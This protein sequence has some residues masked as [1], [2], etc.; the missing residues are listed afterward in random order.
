MLISCSRSTVLDLQQV[1]VTVDYAICSIEPLAVEDHFTTHSKTTSHSVQQLKKTCADL[2]YLYCYVLIVIY[3]MYLSTVNPSY[4]KFAYLQLILAT[5]Q[6]H[7]VY[8]FSTKT[9]NKLYSMYCTCIHVN[10]T[11]I[12]YDGSKSQ[13]NAW[14]SLGSGGDLI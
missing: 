2:A 8:Q 6:I 14:E 1:S 7:T 3:F 9:H 4:Y 11:Q 5:T 12:L 13:H 10:Y